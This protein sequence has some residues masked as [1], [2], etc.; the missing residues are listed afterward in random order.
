[1]KLNM[2]KTFYK[3]VQDAAGKAV[4]KTRRLVNAGFTLAE[5]II[6]IAIFTIVSS[7]A[8]FDQ[9]KLSSNTLLTNMA[10]EIALAVREAQLYGISV[11]AAGDVGNFE[12]EAGAY[13]NIASPRQVVV[14]S[15][16]SSG[17]SMPTYEPGEEVIQYIFQNQ[18]T[19]RIRTICVGKLEGSY[20]PA[21]GTNPDFVA[22]EVHVVF[23]RPNPAPRVY[24]KRGGS[25]ALAPYPGDR[26]YIVVDTGDG[27]NCKVVVIEPTGQTRIVDSSSTL[28]A[29]S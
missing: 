10:Y 26:V 3:S 2:R 23:K 22:T 4:K 12:S 25:D 28:C 11:R 14:Y 27:E 13:F 29:N 6:V 8:L 18:R 21:C 7:I 19:N 16:T 17:T 1:M 20:Q 5:M 24:A 15:N 9:A